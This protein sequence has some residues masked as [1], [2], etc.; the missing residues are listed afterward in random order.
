MTCRRELAGR[1]ALVTGAGPGI[2]RSVATRLAEEGANVVVA[3]RR[4]GPLRKLAAS[5]EKTTGRES[6]PYAMDITDLDRCFALVEAAMARW[7]RIDVVV[8]TATHPFQRAHVTEYDWDDI[9]DSIQ[10][11][12]KGT[13]TISAEAAKQMAKRGSGGSIINIGTLSTTTMVVKNVG[14]TASKAA[15]V[16]ASKTMAREV[17]PH[18]IRVNVVTPGFTEGADLNALLD[19]IATSRGITRDQAREDVAK[20]AMLRRNVE[21]RDIAETVLFL[22]SDRGRNITASEIH[23]TAGAA[24]P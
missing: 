7:G 23:V 2:G 11:N 15:M 16:A 20:E 14:Y 21:P 5:I 18:G 22:A 13:M 19:K 3:A 12:L 24:L 9:D 4:E 1:V 10:L 17:G 6:M 8:N